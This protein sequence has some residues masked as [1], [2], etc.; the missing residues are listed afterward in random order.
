MLT[1]RRS[2]SLLLAVI[3][4]ALWQ[5][6]LTWRLMEQDR[7]L[8]LQHSRERLEQTAEARAFALS[9]GLAIGIWDYAGLGLCLPLP[10]DL[11]VAIGRDLYPACAAEN[12]RVRPHT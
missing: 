12:R 8:E 5:V 11:E 3:G 6:W 1:A 9:A 4:V 2:L 7:N 10:D